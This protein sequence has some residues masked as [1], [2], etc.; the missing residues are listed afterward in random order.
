MKAKK[1]TTALGIA[2]LTSIGVCLAVLNITNVSTAAAKPG[3]TLSN[4]AIMQ[5][6][7]GESTC[8]ATNT[9]KC[10]IVSGNITLYGTGVLKT[11]P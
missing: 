11:N 6:S 4:V 7:A 3:V 10:T 1:I 2:C 5:A 8:D 9:N